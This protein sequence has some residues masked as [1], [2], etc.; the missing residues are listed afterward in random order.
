VHEL[1]GE[2]GIGPASR[3]G[4]RRPVHA[5]EQAIDNAAAAGPTQL[6]LL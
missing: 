1:A 3:G 5:G 6:T 4:F 2:F